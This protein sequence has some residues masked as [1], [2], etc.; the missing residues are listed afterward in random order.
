MKYKEGQMSKK[1]KVRDSL[2]GKN[3]KSECRRQK[4]RK[5]VVNQVRIKKRLTEDRENKMKIGK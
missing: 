2:K 1:E 5:K 4:V 3:K